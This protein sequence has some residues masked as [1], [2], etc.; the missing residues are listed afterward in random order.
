MA[1]NAEKLEF[2]KVPAVKVCT[3]AQ[4]ERRPGHKKPCFCVNLPQNCLKKE[5][6]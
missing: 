5:N 6:S 4:A 3:K 2:M 1:R